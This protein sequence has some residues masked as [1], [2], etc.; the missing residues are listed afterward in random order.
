MME[1]AVSII[2]HKQSLIVA[3]DEAHKVSQN[4]DPRP[5]SVL[6]DIQFVTD[7]SEAKLFSAELIRL[8]REQRHLSCWVLIATQEPTISPQLMDLCD[9]SIIHR[10]NSPVW[11][12]A[13]KGHLTGMMWSGD[14]DSDSGKSAH[15][16]IVN[17]HDGE[18][19]LFCQKAYLDLRLAATTK[20]TAKHRTCWIATPIAM[21][22]PVL[23]LRAPTTT[24]GVRP[25]SRP[26]E[27]ATSGC[28]SASVLL[29]M[30]DRVRWL[31][32]LG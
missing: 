27:Q 26:L 21:R 19:F 12:N 9:V 10:F 3:I 6:I 16:T 11:F 29:R 15:K 20:R 30:G 4:S 14:L 24:R 23:Q 32:E 22:V 13:I 28:R 7:P 5:L 18:A 2:T 25:S 8:L 17:L 31:S 1:F